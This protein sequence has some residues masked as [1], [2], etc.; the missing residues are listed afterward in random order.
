MQSLFH[1]QVQE[2]VNTF[3]MILYE[4][5]HFPTDFQ[6]WQKNFAFKLPW[7][8]KWWRLHYREI[9]IDEGYLKQL[10]YD[11]KRLM[12]KGIKF[13]GYASAK[14]MYIWIASLLQDKPGTL[15]N[16]ITLML[17]LWKEI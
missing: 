8:S 5:V 16:I 3:R 10:P 9:R 15:Q 13:K 12:R 2:V 17:I 11:S 6:G 4:V 7:D 1:N 14:V